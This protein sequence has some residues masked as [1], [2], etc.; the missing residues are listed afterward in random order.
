MPELCNCEPPKV[1]Y[2]HAAFMVGLD[3]RSD[4]STEHTSR[5]IPKVDSECELMKNSSPMTRTGS[6][7]S[8]R[9]QPP[10]PQSN[11]DL[12]TLS[13]YSRLMFQP[14]VVQGGSSS[15]SSS[16]SSSAEDLMW[17]YPGPPG[18]PGKQQGLGGGNCTHRRKWREDSS[19]K[20]LKGSGSKASNT[21]IWSSIP[22]C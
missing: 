10:A 7:S 9:C 20:H 17:N 1:C 18:Y 4:T 16:S 14:D 15:S 12:K 3:I 19:S 21:R 13:S 22:T 11:A 5:L 6:Q 2:S 8:R